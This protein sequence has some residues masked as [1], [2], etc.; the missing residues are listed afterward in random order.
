MSAKFIGWKLA[1]FMAYGAGAPLFVLSMLLCH[2]S[3]WCHDRALRH[4]PNTPSGSD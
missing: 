4:A 1:Q 3:D 2:T